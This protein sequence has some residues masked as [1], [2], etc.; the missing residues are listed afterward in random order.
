MLLRWATV[1]DVEELASPA[2][3]CIAHHGSPTVFAENLPGKEV[4]VLSVE[5]ASCVLVGIDSFLD[6]CKGF[7]I[8]D[9]WTAA[10]YADDLLVVFEK[11]RVSC[12]CDAFGRGF[13]EHVDA[14]VFGVGKDTV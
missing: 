8:D 13:V 3:P 6:F 12:A 1:G 11:V 14:L 2:V 9:S 4:A 10:F 5:S 7:L